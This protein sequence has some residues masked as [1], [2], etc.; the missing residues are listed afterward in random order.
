MFPNLKSRFLQHRPALYLCVLMALNAFIVRRLFLIEFTEHMNSNEGTF[1]AISRFILRDWPHLS[2]FPFWF[3][4][5]PFENTYTPLLH[6]VDAAF[7]KLAGCSTAFAFHAVSATFY[8]LGPALLFW[9]AWKLSGLLETSWSAALLYSLLSPSAVFWVVRTDMFGWRHARRLHT[10]VHYGEGPHNAVLCLLPLAL[11]MAYLALTRG[12]LRWYFASGLC[13][14]VIVLTNAFGAIDLAIGVACLV[15]AYAPELRRVR[16][17]ALIATALLSYLWISPFLTPTLIQTIGKSSS[18]A[19]DFHYRGWNLAGALAVLAGLMIL[20]VATRNMSNRFE[21][22][23]LLLAFVFTAIPGLT[24]WAGIRVLVQPERYHLEME[25]ALCLAAAFFARHLLIRSGSTVRIV[26]VLIFAALLIRQALTYTRYAQTLIRPIDIAST[27]EYKMAK[28]IDGNLP[29]LKTM[30]SDDAGTWFNAFTDNP[31]FSSGHDP[32]SPNWMVEIAVFAIYSGEN[33]GTADAQNSITWLKAYGNHA[34]TVPGPNSR[35]AY[36]PYRNPRKF[37][38]VLPVL[39]HAEDDTI[40]G[41]PQRTRSLAHVI[42]AAAAISRPPEHGLDLEQVTKYVAALDDPGLPLAGMRWLRSGQAHISAPVQPGQVVSVQAT[43]DPGWKAVA[44]GR[45]API[46]RDGIG[47]MVLHPDCQGSCE[48]DLTFEGGLERR[49]CWFASLLVT[50][51][52]VC[53]IGYRL[54]PNR[55]MLKA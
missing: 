44:N 36:K 8:C 11:L 48:I 29:G 30:V 14:G 54:L 3:N 53:A 39:W 23:L 35:E 19:I 40:Y 34:V 32:F 15:L 9:F 42:P 17:A 45:P 6:F 5:L 49:L 4:G 27:V 2:W 38:G 1:M 22:F 47:L 18:L 10:L 24:Y 26:A 7:A 13:F 46:V 25:M 33:A 51:A 31:Q 43:Y 52:T 20:C 16:I 37:E 50:L 28:W 12:R 55:R 41:V 21:R